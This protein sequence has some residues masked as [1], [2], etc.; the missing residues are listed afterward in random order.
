MIVTDA[1]SHSHSSLLLCESKNFWGSLI[2]P[3]ISPLRIY[4][5][6][7][8]GFVMGTHGLLAEIKTF[9]TTK[10]ESLELFTLLHLFLLDSWNPTRL[11]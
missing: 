11:D 1:A 8:V 6:W 4:L 3:I 7:S 2:E 5:R 10:N 9:R